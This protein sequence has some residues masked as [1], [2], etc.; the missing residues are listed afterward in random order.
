MSG[1]RRAAA[2]TAAFDHTVVLATAG[3]EARVEKLVGTLPVDDPTHVTVDWCDRGVDC[4]TGRAE[5][6]HHVV[7]GRRHQRVVARAAREGRRNV[8]VLEDDA[9]LVDAPAVAWNA[10]LTWIAEHPDAWDVFYLGFSAP[11][12]TR[13]SLVTPHVVRP[14]RPF[15]LHAVCY[16]AR[17]FE[18]ILAVDLQADHRPRLHRRIERLLDLRSDEPYFRDGVGSLDT[19]L[20][21]ASVRKLGAHPV[22]IAQTSLPP[23]TEAGWTR[24]TGRRYDPHRSPTEQVTAALAVHYG[25]WALGGLLGLGVLGLAT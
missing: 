16:H 14:R 23:G 5:T 20:S 4:L 25:L 9:E 24:R 22:L 12:L 2:W 10:V 13:C 1:D 11:F 3:A 17:V 15:F 8:L 18:P 7:V 21:F 6:N 19:W